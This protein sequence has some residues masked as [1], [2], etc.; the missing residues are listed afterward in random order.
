MNLH[1]LV[2]LTENNESCVQILLSSLPLFSL[3]TVYKVD[4]ENVLNNKISDIVFKT[5]LSSMYFKHPSLKTTQKIIQ[6][7]KSNAPNCLSNDR[8]TAIQAADFTS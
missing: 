5:N 6:R 8:N 3:G 7:V 1:A 4:F 2:S